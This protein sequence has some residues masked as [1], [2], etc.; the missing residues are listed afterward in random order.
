MTDKP[1]AMD[2]GAAPP[3]SVPAQSPAAAFPPRDA[4][5]S[6]QSRLLM[7]FARTAADHGF[8]DLASRLMSDYVLPETREDFIQGFVAGFEKSFREAAGG[9]ARP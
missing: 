3:P 1:A 2:G 8:A 5:S 6:E 9:R 7:E 4:E